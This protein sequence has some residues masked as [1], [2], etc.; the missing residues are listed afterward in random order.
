M[1]DCAAAIHAVTT[2]RDS[3]LLSFEELHGVCVKL[4]KND[5]TTAGH[6][7]CWSEINVE[8]RNCSCWVSFVLGIWCG[9]R[10]KLCGLE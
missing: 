1:L 6:T 8:V 10:T 7:A 4:A 3:I 5:I 9:L 2:A